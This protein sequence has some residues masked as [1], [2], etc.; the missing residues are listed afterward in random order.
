MTGSSTGDQIAPGRHVRVGEDVGRAVGRADRHVV[1]D[2][3]GRD[4]RRRE[5]RGPLRHDAVDL[6]AAGGPLGQRGEAGVV[7]QVV[8]VHR[9]A[10]AGEV[11]VGP[12]D[13]A[14]VEAVGGGVVVQGSRVRQAVSLPLAHDAQPVVRGQGPLE[15]AQDRRVERGV[16]HLAPARLRC[17]ARRAR[18]PRRTPRRCR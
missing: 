8:A 13:D 12:G 7:G 5:R 15:N 18:R 2:A 14:D 10:E 6:V 16:D 3:A 11:G 1:L 4:L 17:R 9:R